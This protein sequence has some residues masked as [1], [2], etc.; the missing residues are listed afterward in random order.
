MY[1]LTDCTSPFNVTHNEKHCLGWGEWIHSAPKIRPILGEHFFAYQKQSVTE[2][3][4]MCPSPGNALK[5]I[6]RAFYAPRDCFFLSVFSCLNNCVSF[7]CPWQATFPWALIILVT[8]SFVCQCSHLSLIIVFWMRGRITAE[9]MPKPEG[10]WGLLH[11]L[12]KTHLLL[13]ARRR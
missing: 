4:K 7:N 11:I 9:T 10:R 6:A 2:S 8:L 3:W 1:F 13:N 5:V 12:H